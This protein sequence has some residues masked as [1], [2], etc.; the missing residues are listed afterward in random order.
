MPKWIWWA[1][2]GLV[3]LA[4][5][6]MAGTALLGGNQVRCV[7]VDAAGE[8]VKARGN[9]CYEL[10]Q[11]MFF[12]MGDDGQVQVSGDTTLEFGP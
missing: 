11:A 10:N 8:V 1:L 4:A 3:V 5:V 6:P 2:G 12:K 9:Q 7:G